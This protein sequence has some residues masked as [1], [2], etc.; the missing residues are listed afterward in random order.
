MLGVSAPTKNDVFLYSA[1]RE[2]KLSPSHS[3][4]PVLLKLAIGACKSDAIPRML[5]W[6]ADEVNVLGRWFKHHKIR[7]DEDGSGVFQIVAL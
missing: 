4:N 2:D 5:D 1:Y 3:T 6:Q 7:L